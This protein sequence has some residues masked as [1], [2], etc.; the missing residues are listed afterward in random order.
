MLSLIL[1]WLGGSF[2]SSII[3]GALDAYKLKLAAGT[4]QAT[5]AE[6][7]ATQELAVQAKELEL[8]TQLRLA[9]I[10]HFWEPEH[11]FGYIMVIYFGKVV[12]WD[13]VLAMGSTDALTGASAEWAG[14]I[15]M[16]YFGKRG[17]ENV[18]RIWASRSK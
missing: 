13:K 7:L 18:T 9:Q 1:N 2:A 5:L 3:S 15:M 8:Q 10:G 16:F 11:L 14:L 4:S 6:Q 12:L 17:I